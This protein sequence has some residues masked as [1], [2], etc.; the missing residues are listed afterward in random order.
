MTGQ[1]ARRDVP[2]LV[3]V[4][5]AGD[6][7]TGVI[8]KIVR[9]GFMVVALEVTNPSAIRWRAALCPAVTLGCWQVE[10]LTAVRAADWEAARGLLEAWAG[11]GYLVPVLVDPDAELLTSVRPLAVVDAILAKRNLGTHRAMAPVTI[12][13]GPGFSA[14]DDVDLVVETMRGHQLGRV[15]T[16]GPAQPNTGVPGVIAGRAAER[17]VRAPAAGVVEVLHTIGEIVHES[18]V[19]AR[20]HQGDA[21]VDVPASLSGVVRGMIPDSFRVPGGFKIADIDPRLEMADCCDTISD[22]SRSVGG[23]VLEAVLM[24]LAGQGLCR[25][26]ECSPT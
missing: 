12:G 16:R 4:R 22:K 3:V 2:G 9:A 5:G 25:L 19:I 23:A 20:V 15:I 6:I 21:T 24:G 11:P 7:A 26:R 1:N 8:Q 17:V 10:D 14:G 18:D 13:C